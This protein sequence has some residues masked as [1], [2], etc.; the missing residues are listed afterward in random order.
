VFATAHVF[1]LI[2]YKQDCHDLSGMLIVVVLPGMLIVMVLSWQVGVYN[3]GAD[4]ETYGF[5]QVLV[6][7]LLAAVDCS[8]LPLCLFLLCA[9]QQQHALFLLA[10]A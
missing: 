3:G 2:S 8:T 7:F 9:T 5:D 6:L 10:I 1:D 4:W